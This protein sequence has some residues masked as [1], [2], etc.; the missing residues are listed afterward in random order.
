MQVVLD[1]LVSNIVFYS[2]MKSPGRLI[3]RK[4]ADAY[5]VILVDEGIPF[6]PL[7]YRKPRDESEPG[8]LGIDMVRSFVDE[9]SYRRL[10]D[11]NIL[12]IRKKIK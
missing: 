5:C 2:Q 6:N 9:L 12:I 11:K 7:T 8:G 10:D 3:L 1:E 4:E